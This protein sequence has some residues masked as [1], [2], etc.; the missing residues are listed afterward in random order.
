MFP[1]IRESLFLAGVVQSATNIAKHSLSVSIHYICH[2]GVN[3]PVP[4]APANGQVSGN[5]SSF[6]DVVTFKCNLGYNLTG[7]ATRRCQADGSWSGTQPSC[8]SEF[9][10][11]Q[12][13]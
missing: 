4:S 8:E 13:I 6:G 10:H 1:T 9:F 5:G 7:S 2:I 11:M 3:C 12:F